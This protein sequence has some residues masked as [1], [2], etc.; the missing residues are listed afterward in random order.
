MTKT[1]TVRGRQ[2][3]VAVLDPVQVFDEE[4]APARCVAEER[5]DVFARLRIDA[6]PFRGAA[7]ALAACLRALGHENSSSSRDP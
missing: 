4:I 7:D 3:A 2:A 5:P 6:T 1:K